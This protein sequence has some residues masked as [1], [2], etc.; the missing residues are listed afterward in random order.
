MFDLEALFLHVKQ[1]RETLVAREGLERTQKK[2][3]AFSC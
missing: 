2:K 1:G 3:R